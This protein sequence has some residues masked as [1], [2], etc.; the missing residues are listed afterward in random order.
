MV[1]ITRYKN[2]AAPPYRFRP[3]RHVPFFV[4]LAEHIAPFYLRLYMK[5]VRIEATEEDLAMLCQLRGQRVMLTPNH[6]TQDPAVLF[7]F[8]R[9]LGMN[10]YWM[11]ARELFES[12]LQGPII[13]RVGVYS[14][15][16]GRH[17]QTSL[18]ETQQLL[19]DGKHWVVLF[20]EGVNHQLHDQVLPFLPGAA[21]AALEALER[22]SGETVSPP[23]VYLVP[24][25]L[26]YYYLQDMRQT[27]LDSLARLERRLGLP[28][29]VHLGL[30]AR[31]APISLLV[32]EL[33]EQHFNVI[34]QAGQDGDERLD[35][36]KEIALRRVAE[37]MGVELPSS[38]QPLRNRIRKLLNISNQLLDTGSAA[39]GTYARELDAARRGQIVRMR[40]DLGR[41]STFMAMKWNYLGGAP[42]VEN[43]LDVLNLLEMDLL[44]K[45][46]VWG[47]RGVQIKVGQPLDMRQFFDSYQ[48]VPAETI[49]RVMLEVENVVRRLLKSSADHMTPIPQSMI[50]S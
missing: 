29:N 21:R 32:L 11:A 20:P 34:P 3:P 33:N 43:F 30:E 39:G 8:G 14:V 5:V 42:T 17:D 24:L 37:G 16:R 46:R 10:F 1:G 12:R 6:P 31:L 26:R 2:K 40:K 35:R 50:F 19:C 15:D 7:V 45:Q 23:P 49:E 36:L 48:T 9:R 25:A 18:R 22:L 28:S 41:I 47:P 38:D 44:G 27:A 13:S 4:W